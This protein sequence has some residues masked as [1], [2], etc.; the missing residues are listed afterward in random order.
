MALSRYYS[1]LDEVTENSEQTLDSLDRFFTLLKFKFSQGQLTADDCSKMRKILL[2]KDPKLSAMIEAEFSPRDY[3]IIRD[4]MLG[5]GM[6]GGKACGMLLARKIA[7]KHFPDFVQHSES[8]DSWYIGSDVFYTYVVT[9]GCWQL[10]LRQRAEREH[11]SAAGKLGEQLLHGHFPDNIRSQFRRMLDYF[12]PSPII[13]RSSSLQEDGFQNAF[14]GKYESVFCALNGSM[15]E[16][17]ETFENAVR[18]V[19]ASTMSASALE[20]RRLRGLLGRDEQMSVLVQRVSGTRHS[21]YLFPAAA[22]VGYSLNA[23][24]MMDDVDAHAGMLR[25]VGGL[26]TRAVNRTEGDYPRIASL[27]CPL[28]TPL[29]SMRD[30][31]KFS[32]HMVDVLDLNANRFA[33]INA[34]DLLPHLPQWLTCLLFTHDTEAEA[35]FRSRGQRRSILFADCTGLLSNNEFTRFMRT[36]LATLDREYGCPVDT[37]FTVNSSEKGDFLVNLLQCRPL[38]VASGKPVSLPELPNKDILFSIASASMGPSRSE[39]VDIVVHV[40]PVTYYNCA[41]TDKLE[42]GRALGT[43]NHFFQGSGLG[44]MLMAPGRIGTSSPELGLAVS[45]ADISMFHTVCEM[46]C[47]K[48][49]YAPELSYGSHIF[50][51]LVEADILYAALFENEHTLLFA[52][53]KLDQGT[54]MLTEIFGKKTAAVASLGFRVLDMRSRGLHL[55]HDMPHRRTLCA[56]SRA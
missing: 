45:Y 47:D 27:D 31:H 54:D 51:D 13:V 1:L 28:R 50:Q 14:A 20:Y 7:L 9:N 23:Y 48:A 2:T 30:R 42:A 55:Y 16:R 38:Q 19:Y 5:S 43:I 12:G 52:P 41:Y 44:L 37:E 46:A 6:I 21:N 40:D 49:G 3:F 34:Q 11:F 36:L 56:F 15:E 39:P 29:N 10:R 4:R 22:G 33:T 18:T 25:I 53:E 26:G 8:H 32:Q 24:P 35:E 17:L